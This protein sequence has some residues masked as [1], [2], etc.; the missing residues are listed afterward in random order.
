MIVVNSNHDD[1]STM[2]VAKWLRHLKKPFLLLFE[3][4]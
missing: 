1:I 3:D 2:M 4:S